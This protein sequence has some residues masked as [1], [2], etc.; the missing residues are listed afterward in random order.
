MGPKVEEEDAKGR[1]PLH[2]AVLN[3]NLG[4]VKCL[5]EQGGATIDGRCDDY[6]YTPYCLSEEPGSSISERKRWDNFNKDIKPYFDHVL[7]GP[8]CRGVLLVCSR[9]GI[10]A[11]LADKM[12][13]FILPE[14][15]TSVSI[16]RGIL[17][18]I[19]LHEQASQEETV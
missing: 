9:K 2:Y 5:V 8:I 10:I 4:V 15:T 11:D 7:Y 6:G 1:T 16:I 19:A 12:F 14:W 3:G 13:L 17:E 18:E